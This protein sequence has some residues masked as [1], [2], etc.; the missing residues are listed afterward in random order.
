MQ[1]VFNFYFIK[2][3]YTERTTSKINIMVVKFLQIFAFS[4]IINAM[5]VSMLHVFCQVSI[6]AHYILCI[7][8]NW[9]STLGF[10]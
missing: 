6:S 4:G 1:F 5:G 9:R 2:R 10:K 8:M 7:Q 3:C